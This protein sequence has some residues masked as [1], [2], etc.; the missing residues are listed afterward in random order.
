M[1]AHARHPMHPG[2]RGGTIPT[3]EPKALAEEDTA[4]AA[5]HCRPGDCLVWPGTDKAETGD[6]SHNAMSSRGT[7]SY[8]CQRGTDDRRR[9]GVIGIGQVALSLLANVLIGCG[10]FACECLLLDVSV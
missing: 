7:G 4:R 6:T 5:P 3:P 1:Q 8:G 2:G 9:H 10:S